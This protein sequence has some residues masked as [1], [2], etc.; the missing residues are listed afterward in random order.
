MAIV[1]NISSE[2]GDIIRIQT[3]IPII[4]IVALSSFIDD[5][6][7]ESVDVY[8]NKSFRYSVDGGLNFTAWEDLTS[9]NVSNIVVSRKDQFVIDYRYVHAGTEPTSNL[10]FNNLSLSGDFEELPYPVYLRNIFNTFFYVN[11]TKVLT[12]ALNVLE[13]MYSKGIVPDYITRKDEEYNPLVSDTDY[14]VLFNT[15]THFFAIIV[16]YAREFENIGNNDILLRQFLTNIGIFIDDDIIDT[17]LSYLY[18]NYIEEFRKRGTISIADINNS[19]DIPNGELLRL[20]SY[21][22]PEEFVFALLEPHATGWCISKSSPMYNGT[23]QC[24]NMIKGYEKS[25][26]FTDL[27][28]YPIVESGKLALST[29]ELVIAS[30]VTTNQKVGIYPDEVDLSNLLI[31]INSD[32]YYEVIIKVSQSGSVDQLN[33]GIVPYDS[34]GVELSML[35]MNDNTETNFFFN[36]KSLYQNDKDYEIRG[37]IFPKSSYRNVMGLSLEDVTLNIGYG[38]FLRFNEGA[39][40]KF[41][42]PVF[43]TENKAGSSQVT[44]KD[45]K[46]RPMNFNFTLGILGTKNILYMLYNNNSNYTD[47]TVYNNVK[48]KLISYKNILIDNNFN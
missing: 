10:A 16:I 13:K 39:D 33:F 43:Y 11:D 42:L 48:N 21:V 8:F 9:I 27:S 26:G 46:I 12:W 6:T 24:S 34:D 36:D 3:D 23:R 22:Y 17:H 25:E 5:T 37:L 44:I 31:P 47:N 32:L 15:I 20:I 40:I 38:Y 28:N 41:I 7:G 30:N 1:N 4:G 19:V 14:I 18:S 35:T 29:N 45:F 2:I